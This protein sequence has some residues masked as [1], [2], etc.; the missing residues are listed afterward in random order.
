MFRKLLGGRGSPNPDLAA[1]HQQFSGLLLDP[2]EG[3]LDRGLE[4]WAWIGLPKSQ[5]VMV[6][7]FGDVF[8][9]EGSGIL[10]LDTVEGAVRNVA[11]DP[12]ALR[13]RLQNV[14]ARDELLSDVWVQAARRLG[15]ALEPGECF[16]WA[17][18]PALGGPMDA[19][20]VTKIGLVAKLSIA[21]QMHDQLRGFRRARSSTK[22]PSVK[23]TR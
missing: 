13:Q 1:I 10:M 21:G 9:N 23:R 4:G 6:S 22:S 17:V 16:D 5:P 12:S 14:E 3:D 11:H 19:D 2:A 7:A 15:L 20:A 8:Y 18:L